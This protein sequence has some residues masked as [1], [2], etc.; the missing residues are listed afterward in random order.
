MKKF[1]VVLV[2]V[3]VWLGF[4]YNL[5]LI[6]ALKKNPEPGTW[7]IPS[8]L[9]KK[10]TRNEEGVF[11][12]RM[13][14]FVE[15]KMKQAE[16]KVG[17][18]E[19][20]SIDDYFADYRQ[21]QDSMNAFGMNIF[22]NVAGLQRF[23]PNNTSTYEVDVA[24]AKYFPELTKKHR[25]QLSW[26]K[27]SAWAWNVYLYSLPLALLLFLVWLY[28]ANEYRSVRLRNPLSF[29]LCLCLY[30]LVI[31]YNIAKWWIRMTSEALAEIEIRRG[32]DRIFSLLSKD[33]IALVKNFAKS[34][35]SLKQF[36]QELRL[37]GYVPKYAFVSVLFAM[38]IMSIVPRVVLARDRSYDHREAIYQV[39][40]TYDYFS[41]P[42]ADTVSFNSEYFDVP[43]EIRLSKPILQGIRIWWEW[44]VPAVQ[45]G[46]FNGLDHVPL[47][48]KSNST[49]K[50][51]ITT[52]HMI[53]ETNYFSCDR[54]MHGHKHFWAD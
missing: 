39:S 21:V 18:G 15:D 22:T 30:P 4:F 31:G 33:E 42:V 14:L 27:V 53:Y 23:V 6:D 10:H 43:L 16:A 35:S 36:R 38:I 17:R 50:L 8:V 28:E 9:P 40:H 25:S 26:K 52:K 48:I 1:L 34:N 51:L 29:L 37:K 46:H 2:K 45:R 20:Y 47:A 24:R 49:E 3:L 13:F 7:G 19:I 54:S 5:G 41:S 44:F 12:A 32:K 11:S